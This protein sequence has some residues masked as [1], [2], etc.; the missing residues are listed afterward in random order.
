M[1]VEREEREMKRIVSIVSAVAVG[2][3]AMWV[4]A[5]S[6]GNASP[7]PTTR[8][9]TTDITYKEGLCSSKGV[10][11]NRDLTQWNPVV[12]CRGEHLL[13]ELLGIS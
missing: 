13:G 8:A 1:Q 9:T 5:M 10:S 4:L 12:L 3:A 6:V 11:R 2:A 7:G